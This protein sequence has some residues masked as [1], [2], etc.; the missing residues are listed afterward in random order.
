MTV[1]FG[2]RRKEKCAWLYGM[3]CLERVTIH[4]QSVIF[5]DMALFEQ[6]EIHRETLKFQRE[7]QINHS[8]VAHL[9]NKFATGKG[10]HLTY[11]P[12]TLPKGTNQQ[13]ATVKNHGRPPQP[14][15]RPAVGKLVLVF[16]TTDPAKVTLTN[17]IST[18]NKKHLTAIH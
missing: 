18:E 15:S 3:Q 1:V 14:K 5:E 8:E 6:M 12:G 11:S 2:K 13:H 9:R 7:Q 4:P 17:E 10:P 16:V